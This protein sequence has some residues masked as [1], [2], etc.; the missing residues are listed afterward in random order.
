MSRLFTQ[1]N[2]SKSSSF[3]IL[4]I[5]VGNEVDFLKY[6]W[7]VMKNTFSGLYSHRDPFRSSGRG[8]AHACEV[9]QRRKRKGEK[10]KRRKRKREKKKKEVGRTKEVQRERE[11]TG[12]HF[13]SEQTKGGKARK[14]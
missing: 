8:D 5:P 12:G 14:G 3:R 7:L 10:K 1:M 9:A 13:D 11:I 2:Q 6:Q 4:K